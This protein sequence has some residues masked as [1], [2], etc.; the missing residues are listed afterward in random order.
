MRLRNRIIVG[1][2]AVL[3]GFF[4]L[5]NEPVDFDKKRLNQ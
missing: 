3:V 4:L 2:A 5:P 1:F